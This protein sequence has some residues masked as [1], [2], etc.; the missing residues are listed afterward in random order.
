MTSN[1]TW[2]SLH[3][4][5]GD[6]TVYTDGDAVISL[7]WG[8]AP[9]PPAPAPTVLKDTQDQLNAYFDGDLTR[10]DVP[11]SLEGTAYRTKVWGALRGIPYGTTQTYGDVARIIDSCPRAV[12]TACGANPV[13]IIVPCHRVISASG[14][15]T[16]YSGG[17][18]V[19]TKAQ[20]L[21]LEGAIA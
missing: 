13:P 2:I 12:G 7:D 1:I 15:L 19:T 10:F 9:E 20:L 5:V 4:P 8:W 16:G 3:S 11:L 18:G 6:L 21:H 17:E 14:K